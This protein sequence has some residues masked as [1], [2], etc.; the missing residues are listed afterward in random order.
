MLQYWVFVQSGQS[1]KTVI[2]TSRSR[3]LKQNSVVAKVGKG[4]FCVLVSSWTWASWRPGMHCLGSNS[5]MT[6]VHIAT[7]KLPYRH[8]CQ[9]N[10]VIHWENVAK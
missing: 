3:R 1:I 5:P 9:L 2:T 7:S 10:E 8:L 4:I 6:A